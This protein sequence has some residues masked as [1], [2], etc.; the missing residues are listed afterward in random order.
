MVVQDSYVLISLLGHDLV[1]EIRKFE[2]EPVSES[3]NM[4]AYHLG[5]HLDECYDVFKK[6][7]LKLITKLKKQ[8]NYYDFETKLEIQEEIIDIYFEMQHISLHNLMIRFPKFRFSNFE[9]INKK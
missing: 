7:C 9:Q 6:Q 4:Y 5:I 2:S 1:E 3:R 8:K